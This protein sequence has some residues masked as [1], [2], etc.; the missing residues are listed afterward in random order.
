M[1]RLILALDSAGAPNRWIDVEAAAHYYAK[2]LVAWTVGEHEW[3]LRGGTV[4]TMNPLQIGLVAGQ[5]TTGLI[6]ALFDYFEVR[7]LP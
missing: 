6:P 5:N 4:S 3:I 2:Q 7:S 1:S